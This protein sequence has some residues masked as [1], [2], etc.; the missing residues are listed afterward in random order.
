MYPMS[1]TPFSNTSLSKPK[2]GA[3]DDNYSTELAKVLNLELSR[4]EV[5]SAKGGSGL[6]LIS[7]LTP[8]NPP[9]PKN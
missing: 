8:K 3:R 9:S 7:L 5:G 1:I 6:E 4:S 2:F